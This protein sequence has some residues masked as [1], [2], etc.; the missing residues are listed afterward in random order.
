MRWN[1]MVRQEQAVVY[2]RKSCFL[3]EPKVCLML[4]LLPW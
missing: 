3:L 4:I 1:G 2:N